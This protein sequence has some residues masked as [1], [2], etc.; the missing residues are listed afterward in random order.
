MGNTVEPLKY[1]FYEF[2]IYDDIYNCVFYLS[3]GFRKD[4]EDMIAFYNS[5]M[6]HNT[7]GI[8][9][10]DGHGGAVVSKLLSQNFLSFIIKRLKKKISIDTIAESFIVYDNLLRDELKRSGLY[11]GSTAVIN[12][13]SNNKLYIAHLGDSR[14]LVCSKNNILYESIDHKPDNSEEYKRIISHKASVYNNRINGNLNLS[15]AF[16]DYFYKQLNKYIVSNIPYVKTIPLNK[17]YFILLFTDGISDVIDNYELYTYVRYRLELGDSI[18]HIT[19]N[20]IHACI[21][22][23]SSDNMTICIVAKEGGFIVNEGYKS[24]DIAENYRIVNEIKELIKHKKYSI[25]SIIN[26]LKQTSTYK[27]GLEYKYWLIEKLLGSII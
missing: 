7:V 23:K 12:I 14:C 26:E 8:G 9:V 27:F 19:R 4:M 6:Y 3:K 17:V 15:R 16:G 10:F 18:Q 20:I 24:D 5:N 1:N 21:Y 22:R 11:Q 13:I 25:N 2:K